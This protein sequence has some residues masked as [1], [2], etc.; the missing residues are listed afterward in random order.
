MHIKIQNPPTCDQLFFKKI[1]WFK[2]NKNPV[3]M[4]I[5][6]QDYEMWG[7]ISAYT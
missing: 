5:Q 6:D 1:Y 4:I 2:D 7:I 3:L